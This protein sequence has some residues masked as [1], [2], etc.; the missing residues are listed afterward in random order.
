MSTGNTHH[1]RDKS[2]ASASSES[3]YK[4]TISSQNK[5]KKVKKASGYS[6]ILSTNVGSKSV[7]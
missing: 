3:K 6:S 4:S 1:L 7:L 2:M 5:A